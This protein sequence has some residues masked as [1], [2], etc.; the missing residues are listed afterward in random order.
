MRDGW[1]V[2]VA[3]TH[4]NLHAIY[5]LAKAFSGPLATI[6]AA[7]AATWI[8]WKFGSRQ[9]G[10]MLRQAAIAKQGADTALEQL[11]H[12]LYKKRYK[13]F[14]KV[15]ELLILVIN[16]PPGKRLDLKD[17]IIFQSAIYEARFLFSESVC[18]WLRT[19]WEEDVIRFLKVSYELSD[20][21]FSS[22]INALRNRLINLQS[23][24]E[25]D[26]KFSFLNSSSDAACNHSHT[27][28]S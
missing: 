19:L 16:W 23:V 14:D 10:I 6:I 11:R 4:Q 3:R 8:T 15:F 13:I 7:A 20:P 25:T 22:T 2:Y 1:I 18:E 17:I 28:H 27:P 5:S 21:D 9:H 12:D 24:F 26:M